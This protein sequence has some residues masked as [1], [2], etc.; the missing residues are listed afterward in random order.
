MES[1]KKTL[2]SEEQI[3]RIQRTSASHNNIFDSDYKKRQ[4][5][6]AKEVKKYSFVYK[7]TDCSYF[8][9]PKNDCS[10]GFPLPEKV[11]TQRGNLLE[12]EFCKYFEID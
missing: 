4:E 1:R 12:D 9:L 10:M 7:C 11:Q 2:N 3:S 5:L 6:F 8:D